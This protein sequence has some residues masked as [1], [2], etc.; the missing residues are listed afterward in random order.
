MSAIG[1][2]KLFRKSA[3][4]VVAGMDDAK[5]THV[6]TIL[7]VGCPA[8]L[9]QTKRWWY[10]TGVNSVVGCCCPWILL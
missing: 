7:V 4:K 10:N 8:A 3:S 6:P 1:A 9:N 2:P 5:L